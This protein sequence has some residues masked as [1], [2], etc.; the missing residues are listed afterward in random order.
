MTFLTWV[1]SKK[2]LLKSEDFKRLIAEGV[3][4][5]TN[6]IEPFIGGGSVA[7]YV[8]ESWNVNLLLSDA[9]RAL[10]NA[11]NCVMN[12]PSEVTTQVGNLVEKGDYYEAR[13]RFNDG[14]LSDVESAGYFIYLNRMC[15]RGLHRECKRG[16][17]NVPLDLSR[18][19][20]NIQRFLIEISEFRNATTDATFLHDSFDRI[21]RRKFW[22]SADF[23]Y[24]D[25]PYLGEFST[26]NSKGFTL[27]D[28]GTLREQLYYVSS[29]GGKFLLSSSD[30]PI[31]RSWY[32]CYRILE[33]EV[34]RG[35]GDKPSLRTVKELLI[36]NY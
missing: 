6:Y 31:I 7:E 36:S 33:V 1:G 21:M 10:I 11:Y 34:R 4:N 32:S 19:P 24:A 20:L 9:N 16:R 5:S 2:N 26:Y 30:S 3:Q 23:V 28:H 13:D 12:S 17:F 18:K 14:K 27:E 15:H 25:P 35:M 22:S 8:G 29:Q